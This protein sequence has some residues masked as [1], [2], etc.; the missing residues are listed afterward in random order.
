VYVVSTV[1]RVC[2]GS[3]LDCATHVHQVLVVYRRYACAALAQRV[4][5]IG[6]AV[7]SSGHVQH[8]EARCR[9]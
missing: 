5:C 4:C 7:T 9:D 8:V 3:M 6:E 1:T 2:K